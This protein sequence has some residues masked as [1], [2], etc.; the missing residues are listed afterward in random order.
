MA[1]NIEQWRINVAKEYVDKLVLEETNWLLKQ[2]KD[3]Y[4]Y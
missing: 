3:F 2:T 4:D 1:K